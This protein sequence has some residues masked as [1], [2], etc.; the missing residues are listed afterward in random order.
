MVYHAAYRQR[1]EDLDVAVL[2]R[3]KAMGLVLRSMISQLGV[4]SVRIFQN[5]A[6]VQNDL[7]DYAPQLIVLDWRFGN[8]GAGEV[9]K[10]IRSRT[11]WPV[12][13]APIIVLT[14]RATHLTVSQALRAGAQSLVSK[15]LAS[16]TLYQHIMA[17]L[18]DPRELISQGDHYVLSGIA[19]FDLLRHLVPPD[20]PHAQQGRSLNYGKRN[21]LTLRRAS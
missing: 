12:C 21:Q 11:M 19:S 17:V 16:S 15:P 7:R 6:S 18:D 9:I 14:N 5:P 4:K 3:N 13:F 20:V 1:L 10:A 8:N 2:D